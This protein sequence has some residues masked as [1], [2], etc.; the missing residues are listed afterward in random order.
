MLLE[1]VAV[2]YEL[3][4]EN[5]PTVI[6]KDIVLEKGELTLAASMKEP[7]F[8][9]CKVT[10]GIDGYTYTGLATVAYSEDRI[11]SS[12]PD[13]AD[14]DSFWGEAVSDAR[15]TPLKPRLRLLEDR[16]TPGLN[17]Y[18]ACFQNDRANSMI[19]G[20]LNIPKK[21]GKYPAVIQTPGAGFRPRDGVDFGDD[22]ITFE[23]G[24]HGVPVTFEKEFYSQLGAGA[25]R[26]YSQINMDDKNRHY[27]KRV[28]T[29]CV[30]AVD[31]IF[32]LPQFDGVNIGVTG[33]S[34]GGALAIVTAALDPRVKFL[35]VLYP[36]LCDF[37][38]YLHHR[39]GGWPHYFKNS[40][41]RAGEAETLS[42]YDVVNFARRIKVKGWYSWGYND[43]T[44]PPT[45]MYAAYNSIQAPK[46]LHIY[47]ITGHWTF[48]EQQAVRRAWIRE[49]LLK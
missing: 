27:Y 5:F 34:Q 36:A 4:P 47:P 19:Y 21:P 16:C 45:S 29:G 40:K 26:N 1:N 9:R 18:E 41:P 30:R 7:G 25:L 6:K 33:G 49:Q 11:N 10:A 20:L 48:P 39:A 35:S 37:S 32:D 13:P 12:T 22:V 3:G 44:C 46:E 43:T 28:Y 15:K 42:Y 14:F 8:L 31:F 17:V 23:I 38:G 2:D 24:I